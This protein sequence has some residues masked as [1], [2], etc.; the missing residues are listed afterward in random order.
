MSA[1][2][3]DNR[4]R[5]TASTIERDANMRLLVAALRQRPML[6]SEISDLFG[7]SLSGAS[8]YIRELCA[9]QLLTLESSFVR[10]GA[11]GHYCLTADAALVD[12]YLAAIDA[13]DRAAAAVH[14]IAPGPVQ[15]TSRAGPGAA[16]RQIHR[17]ADDWPIAAPPPH[18]IPAPDPLLAAF[19]GMTPA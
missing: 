12:A 16:G 6:R 9:A 3:T 11:A 8:K 18:R 5:R 15:R 10:G 14:A 7:Y 2:L 1:D 19:Y 17:T 4:V 13:R